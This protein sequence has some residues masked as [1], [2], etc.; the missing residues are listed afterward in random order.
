MRPIARI[1]AA[2]NSCVYVITRTVPARFIAASNTASND[3]APGST[4]SCSLRAARTQH[5]HGLHPRGRA[6]RRHECARVADRLDVE[7]DA[8]GARV[9]DER[10]EQLAEADVVGTAQRHD[11]RE[12][13]SERRRE[14]QHRGA[15]GARLRDQRETPGVRDRGPH[16]R[17]ETDVGADHAERVRSEQ[18]DAP[19][20]RG[21][22]HLALPA[23]RLAFV[24][25]RRGQD[26]RRLHAGAPAV[27]E[28]RGHRGAGHGD[29][30]ELDRLA[31]RAQR[32]MTAPIE[33]A[34]VMRVDEVELALEIALEQVLDDDAT[35]RAGAARRPDEGDRRGHEQRT[36]VMLQIHQ[37]C[38]RGW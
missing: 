3:G 11:R 23:P 6:Q 13:D 30:R 32:R 10:V 19:L 15:H 2:E 22:H 20:A 14:V 25:R 17:V 29:Q 26:D 7:Q 5:D 27:V 37:K 28:H 34:A 12:A 18:A 8:V 1:R 33:H 9:A 36:Q 38:D 35:E 4:V 24:D 16:R 31:D 21:R